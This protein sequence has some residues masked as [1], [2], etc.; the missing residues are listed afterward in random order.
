MARRDQFVASVGDGYLHLFFTMSRRCCRTG[1]RRRP[2]MC[3]LP[4]S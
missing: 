1:S 3:R 2:R 4:G